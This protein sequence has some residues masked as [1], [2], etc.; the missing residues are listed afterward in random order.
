M[1]GWIGV[2][3]DGTLVEHDEKTWRGPEH[4]GAPIPV[5]VERVKAWLAAGKDVRIFT[6]RV[7][8]DGTPDRNVAAI[9]ARNAVQAWTEEHFGQKLRV[10]CEKDYQ[11]IEL[12][13]DHAVQVAANTGIALQEILDGIRSVLM[14]DGRGWRGHETQML[15]EIEALANSALPE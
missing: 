12:W 3:L 2:D 13:D 15:D 4:F 7:Y 14:N 10:T 1:S 5:M 11:M 8:T 6:A 9:R